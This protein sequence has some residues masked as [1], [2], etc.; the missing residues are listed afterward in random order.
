MIT[1]CCRINLIT[2][3]ITLIRS[4][5]PEFPLVGDQTVPIDL[6]LEPRINE[7]VRN[8]IEIC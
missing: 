3:D 5:S 7:Q 4:F 8:A 1:V 2:I 6:I